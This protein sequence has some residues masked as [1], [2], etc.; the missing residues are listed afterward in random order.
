MQV[1]GKIGDALRTTDT[2]IFLGDLI[3]SYGETLP[4]IIYSAA[5][6]SLKTWAKK[7]KH[8]YVLVGNHDRYR[9]LS[10]VHTFEEIDNVTV[11]SDSAK[12]HVEGYEIDLISWLS[13]IPD[14]KGDILAAHLMP[15]GAQLGALY[16]AR[17]EEGVPIQSFAGYRYIILGHCHEPQELAIPKS[18]A[19]VQCIG[20]IMQLNLSSSPV[21]RYLHRLEGSKWSKVEIKSNK[22]YT[23]V[24]NDQREAD[25]FFSSDREPGYYKLIL[26]DHTIQTPPQDHTVVIEYDI[27]PKAGEQVIDDIKDIDL[28]ETINEFIDNTN[29]KIDKKLAKDYLAKMY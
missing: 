12:I 9:N 28:L 22:L 7:C 20:S 11:V 23:Q 3:D 17:S 13:P 10:I 1:V 15:I 14:N 4:K 27:K 25:R 24:I 19:V 21:P 5:F 29:T 6:H 18:P 2:A 16:R 26:T 8:L